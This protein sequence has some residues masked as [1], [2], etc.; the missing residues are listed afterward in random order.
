[1]TLPLT[2]DMLAGAYEFLRATPPFNKW[3][4]P[5]ADDVE[6]HVIRDA[7]CR[8]DYQHDKTKDTHRI[9]ISSRSGNGYTASL[10]ATVAHE[11]VHAAEHRYAPDRRHGEHGARFKRMAARVCKF[12]GFDPKEF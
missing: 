3:R 7:H 12:H 8:G 11:M 1:M 4:L 2:P 6:F 9:R 5:H 10:L